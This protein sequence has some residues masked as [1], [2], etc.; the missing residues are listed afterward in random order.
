[1]FCGKINQIHCVTCVPFYPIGKR[2]NSYIC[3]VLPLYTT[4]E[5]C[6]LNNT[7]LYIFATL[8]FNL[9]CK[10]RLIPIALSISEIENDCHKV[11]AA[12]KDINYLE[13]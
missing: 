13:I 5:I 1:M 12:T 4:T 8:N 2:T 6:Y 11:S 10:H 9:E 3:V 7:M